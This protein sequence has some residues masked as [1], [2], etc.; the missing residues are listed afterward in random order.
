MNRKLTALAAVTFS[1]GVVFTSIARESWPSITR[2][3]LRRQYGPRSS[4]RA[5]TIARTGIR[6]VPYW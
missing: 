6:R 3:K 1:L 5:G 2:M 4:R